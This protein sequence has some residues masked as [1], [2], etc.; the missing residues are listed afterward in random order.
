MNKTDL[1]LY[2]IYGSNNGDTTTSLSIIEQAL[3]SGITLFQLREKGQ[4]ALTGEA[5]RDFA[6]S[7]QKLTTRYEVPFIIND[8]VELALALKADGIHIGQ[9]DMDPDRLPAYFD[10]KIVGLS[11]RDEAELAVSCLDNVSYIGTG[12]V[13]PTGS[14]D[15]AGAAIGVSGL[16]LMRQKIGT[17]PMVAIGGITESNYTDCITEGADGIAVISAIAGA[18]NIAQAVRNFLN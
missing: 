13:F 5:L 6:L 3:Q 8:D 11:V 18:D 15:D 1:R 17:L 14:K 7:V 4:G 10:D 2:F 12:P 16:K 9:D